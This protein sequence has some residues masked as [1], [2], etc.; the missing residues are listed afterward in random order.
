M[1]LFVALDMDHRYWKKLLSIITISFASVITP[2]S[3]VIAGGGTEFT[4]VKKNNIYKCAK[5][6]IAQVWYYGNVH[7]SEKYFSLFCTDN[8]FR[9][10]KIYAQWVLLGG[11]IVYTHGDFPAKHGYEVS[12]NRDQF[13]E[14]NNSNRQV[15]KLPKA[16]V[17]FDCNLTDKGWNCARYSQAYKNLE[18][19]TTIAKPFETGTYVSESFYWDSPWR[20]SNLSENQYLYKFCDDEEHGYKKPD[21]PE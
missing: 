4:T 18:V 1:K 10:N 16:V 11:L 8:N 21:C 5:N 15:F 12:R 13:F 20:F 19:V 2:Y 17:G 14:I 9:D 3:K 6:H 7:G